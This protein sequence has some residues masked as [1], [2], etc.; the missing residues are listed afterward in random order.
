MK[1]KRSVAGFA[2][3]I[4]QMK[5]RMDI[6][7]K[8]ASHAARAALEGQKRLRQARPNILK[9]R[10]RSKSERYPGDSFSTSRAHAAD[11]G[12]D[13]QSGCS[14]T[15]DSVQQPHVPRIPTNAIAPSYSEEYREGVQDNVTTGMGETEVISERIDELLAHFENGQHSTVPDVPAA[16]IA[17]SGSHETTNE[18]A[19]YSDNQYHT[20]GNPVS[21]TNTSS[22][23]FANDQ[24]FTARSTAHTTRS[25]S[26]L[27]Y[28][29]DGSFVYPDSQYPISQTTTM[30]KRGSSFTR[31]T[32][33]GSCLYRDDSHATAQNI[34]TECF[35]SWRL[36]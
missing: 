9:P 31:N 4:E 18:P 35:D 33:D 24:H 3:T 29:M 23:Y 26:F 32:M 2:K 36:T 22:T 34:A 8:M 16:A 19:I 27:S 1:K 30:A 11:H 15:D 25:S 5:S 6:E 14:S 10:K 13:E 7:S 21:A 20:T 17:P 28:T 12:I